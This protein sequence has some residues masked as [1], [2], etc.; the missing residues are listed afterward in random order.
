MSY[1]FLNNKII[2][3]SEAKISI[4]DRAL[5]FADGIYEVILLYSGNF[6]DFKSHIDRLFSS[7][8]KINIDLGYDADELTKK[9]YEFQKKTRQVNNALYIQITRGVA[10]RAQTL[11][12]NSEPTVIMY[13][14]NNKPLD[15]KIVLNGFGAITHDDIRWKKCEIKSTSILANLLC[16]EKANEAAACEAILIENNEVTEGSF[17]NIFIIDKNNKLITRPINDGRIL[18]GITRAR[19]LKLA[20][21]NNINTEIRKFTKEELFAAKEVFASSATMLIRPIIK[22]DEQIIGSG[23]TGDIT[24]KLI[25]LYQDFLDK[26]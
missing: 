4:H 18:P 24:K 5:Q 26:S 23:K 10:A 8:A 6:I 25:S 22:I 2:K 20:V 13:F 12:I 11:K 14:L 15:K 19:I 9:I 3:D 17:S 1:I 7:L 21:Q 16:K